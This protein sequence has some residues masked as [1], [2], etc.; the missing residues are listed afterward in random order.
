VA[1]VSR[2]KISVTPLKIDRTDDAVLQSLR[3]WKL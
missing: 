1:A 3:E 2:G